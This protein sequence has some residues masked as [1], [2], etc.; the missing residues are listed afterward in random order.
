M[1]LMA[2]SRM[3][4]KTVMMFSLKGIGPIDFKRLALLVLSAALCLV[5]GI[6]LVSADCAVSLFRYTAYW[7]ILS[8]VML[9]GYVGWQMAKRWDWRAEWKA[10]AKEWPWW[11]VV[12]VVTI[13]AVFVHQS[14]GLKIVN[15]EPSQLATAKSLFEQREA[16]MVY[17][18]YDVGEGMAP[19]NVVVDKRPILYAWVVAQ[20][21]TLTGYRES[22]GFWV[23]RGLS[24]LA[25]LAL[26]VL[27]RRIA[28]PAGGSVM[29]LL[30]LLAPM[31]GHLSNSGGFEIMNLLFIILLGL[32]LY[33]YFDRPGRWTEA[34]LVLTFVL[35]ASLRYES[36]VFIAPVAIALLVSWKRGTAL[37]LGWPVLLTPF[38]M[39][40]RLWLQHVFT[41]GDNWQLMSKPEAQGEPFSYHFLYDNVGHALN[42]FFSGAD[43]STN[44]VVLA[45]AGLG[46][47]GFWV[48]LLSRRCRSL[49]KHEL[50]GWAPHVLWWGL[51]LHF[52]LMMVYFW[53]QFDDP[54]TQRLALPTHL[55]LAIPVVG[56]LAT[57]SHWRQWQAPIVIGLVG[58]FWVSTVPQLH[59]DRF[60]KL[61]HTARFQN[62]VRDWMG[63]NPAS[64]RLVVN[65]I[66]M[67]TWLSGE[68]AVVS[69][70]ALRQ[71]PERIR[72]HWAR[73][74]FSEVLAVMRENYN[75]K[76]GEWQVLPADQL[77][78]DFDYE[79][80]W[81]MWFTPIYRIRLVRIT[82]I[83]NEHP[84][85]APAELSKTES[86]LLRKGRDA[87]FNEWS[88][89]MP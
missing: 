81:S 29:A 33:W 42:Y 64:H 37:S 83:R 72:F 24:I 66:A 50:S 82:D 44:S 13:L 67:A 59:A 10:W 7:F 41:Q 14:P 2:S 45:V 26:Y 70:E 46:C 52:A 77:G 8:T 35:L 62:K 17:R 69:T 55:W 84:D 20:A 88:G 56:L 87:Y 85:W 78:P 32:A 34:W 15:D 12:F 1:D 54:L 58:M 39:L 63:D 19:V 11:G 25:S 4:M 75:H 31:Q 86:A 9:W 65:G 3:R 23:T 38:L 22:N 61:N 51:G 18:A 89:H 30:L 16:A 21:H 47:A 71:M 53:G 40:P 60:Y 43:T 76:E 6:R 28:G 74:T 68:N 80:V 57:W 36:V 73:G 79:E 5:F 48:M 49:E 27:G